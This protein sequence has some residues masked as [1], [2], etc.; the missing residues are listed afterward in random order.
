ML[1][2]GGADTRVPAAQGER[3]H[4]E[5]DRRHIAHEWLYE[6]SEGHGFYDVA[7]TTELYEKIVAFLDAQIGAK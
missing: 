1:V 7:H 5:L 4:D 6:R 3:L 2:V